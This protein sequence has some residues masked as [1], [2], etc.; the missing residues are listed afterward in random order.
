MPEAVNIGTSAE[1]EAKKPTVPA[2]SSA[3]T[4]TGTSRERHSAADIS[5]SPSRDPRPLVIPR[6]TIWY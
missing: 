4:Q 6:T 1:G 3:D 2:S 5:T